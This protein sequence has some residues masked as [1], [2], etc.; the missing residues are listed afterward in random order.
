[1][2]GTKMENKRDKGHYMLDGKS[3]HHTWKAIY[4]NYLYC[5]NLL[6]FDMPGEMC[7]SN[8]CLPYFFLSFFLAFVL[9]KMATGTGNTRYAIVKCQIERKF[10]RCL[11]F[12]QN[13][14]VN[15]F[16]YN[17]FF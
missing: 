11:Y 17:P 5:L 16:T 2:Q 6:L 7:T 12:E 3:L 13:F 1:M 8:S 10:Y 14:N 9:F 4:Q 15:C